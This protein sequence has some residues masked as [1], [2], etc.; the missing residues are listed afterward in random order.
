MTIKKNKKMKRPKSKLLASSR[1]KR[2]E[3]EIKTLGV[4]LFENKGRLFKQIY[5]FFRRYRVWIRIGL[6]IV[7]VVAFLMISSFSYKTGFY[8][9]VEEWEKQSRAIHNLKRAV[10]EFQSEN[11]NLKKENISL[12]QQKT[13]KETENLN[14]LEQLKQLTLENTELKEDKLL[15]Q[16]VMEAPRSNAL[17]LKQFH[18]YP[19]ERPNHFRYQLLLTSLLMHKKLMQGEVTMAISGKL[20]DREISIP[21]RYLPESVP[22]KQL[23]FAFKQFQELSGTMVLPTDF[24]PKFI[25]VSIVTHTTPKVNISQRVPW[26]VES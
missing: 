20:G 8:Q 19:G 4:L 14:I 24:E 9:G 18:L 3:Q 22:S 7:I 5:K 23:G 16:S 2:H 26:F 11:Q 12:L 1:S 15:Y 25:V 21:L 6:T 17:A 13:I 10:L